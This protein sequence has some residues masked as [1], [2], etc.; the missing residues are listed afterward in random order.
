MNSKYT[1]VTI[2]FATTLIF[3]PLFAS[4][5]SFS[6][7]LDAIRE[8]ASQ[9]SAQLQTNKSEV[10]KTE[11][12]DNAN[13]QSE[14][15]QCAVNE[16]LR[17]EN[18]RLKDRIAELEEQLNN[19]ETIRDTEEKILDLVF[20]DPLARNGKEYQKHARNWENE[21]QKEFNRLI[22]IYQGL[23]PDFE[24]VSKPS[25]E[26]NESNQEYSREIEDFGE[27]FAD[28]VD[29]RRGTDTYE[30]LYTDNN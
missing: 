7:R 10:D 20:T 16:D 27:Y 14:N 3:S 11:K 12:E 1:I 29:T 28:W 17:E 19:S 13:T 4:A 8:A 9:I 22:G 21:D 2:V 5:Q 18:N 6:D 25:R 23:V 30:Y 26:V 24:P 15:N